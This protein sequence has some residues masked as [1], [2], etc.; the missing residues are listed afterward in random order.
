MPG[1]QSR[2]FRHLA[3]EWLTLAR[4]ASEAQG[5]ASLLFTAQKWFELAEGVE[6]E[7]DAL[8][9]QHRAI[10]MAIGD[11]LKNLYAVSADVP[12]DFL[13]VL[14]RLDGENRGALR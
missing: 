5:R 6:H 11:E 7:P 10:Q 12:P 4:R 13:A 9:L 1:D 8:S 3:T 2:D 14:A